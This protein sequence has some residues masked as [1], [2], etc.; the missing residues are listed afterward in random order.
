MK[1]LAP[2]SVKS[3][4]VWL[5][6]VMALQKKTFHVKILEL[7]GVR[8]HSRAEFY[9]IHRYYQQSPVLRLILAS[10]K[11]LPFCFSFCFFS[12]EFLPHMSH[13]IYLLENEILAWVWVCHRPHFGH[14]YPVSSHIC[15]IGVAFKESASVEHFACDKNDNKNES[16]Y[17]L[18]ITSQIK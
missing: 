2:L 16:F 11:T 10:S 17:L 14:D 1:L 18:F 12:F 4:I 15:V 3:G 8:Q 13:N 6:K 9:C 5:R 7:G